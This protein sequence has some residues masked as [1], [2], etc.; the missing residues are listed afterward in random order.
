LTIDWTSIYLYPPGLSCELKKYIIAFFRLHQIVFYIRTGPERA[1]RD[2]DGC[3]NS[4]LIRKILMQKGGTNMQRIIG[5]AFLLL[6]GGTCLFSESIDPVLVERLV[7][8]G[9][10]LER[11]PVDAIDTASYSLRLLPAGAI[12]GSAY[13]SGAT[14]FMEF[15]RGSWRIENGALLLLIERSGQLEGEAKH[16]T[17]RMTFS[18]AGELA[19]FFYDTDFTALELPFDPDE[20]L[21][22]ESLFAIPAEYAN[23]DSARF[24]ELGLTYHGKK[25]YRTSL[26]YFNYSILRDPSNAIGYF[27]VACSFTL[28]GAYGSAIRYLSKSFKHD[29][30]WTLSVISD[31]DIDALRKT[32]AFKKLLA[33]Y[34]R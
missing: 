16:D 27:D 6:T 21:L 33:K 26:R 1:V 23:L 7:A 18:G 34:A 13:E 4:C 19:A 25:D 17:K 15:R 29:P 11:A 32:E 20:P 24:V 5:L 10:L 28:L 22:G 12:A 9:V 8:G 3:V 14:G 2:A 30:G 31:P